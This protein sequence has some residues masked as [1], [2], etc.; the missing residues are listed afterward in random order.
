[1][2]FYKGIKTVLSIGDYIS[3]K[4]GKFS[5]SRLDLDKKHKE[6]LFFEIGGIKI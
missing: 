3:Y 4:A 5:I 1:M 2:L 6:L